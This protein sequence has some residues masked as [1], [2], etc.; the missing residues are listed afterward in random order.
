M[1]IAEEEKT[2]GWERSASNKIM[3]AEE[4]NVHIK[5]IREI[6]FEVSDNNKL[7]KTG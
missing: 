5:R 2:K 1:K 7:K 3:R 4:L 6:L